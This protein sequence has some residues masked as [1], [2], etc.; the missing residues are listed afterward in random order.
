[1][2]SVSREGGGT[3]MRLWGYGAAPRALARARAAADYARR[4]GCGIDEADEIVSHVSRRRFLQGAGALVSAAALGN[5]AEAAAFADTG[6]RKSSTPK[7]LVVGSGMAGLGCA[8]KLWTDY[9][10]HSQVY[11]YN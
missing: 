6:R 4:S 8:Y 7:I 10:I 2:R 1:M 11:E 3:D 9:G 5:L